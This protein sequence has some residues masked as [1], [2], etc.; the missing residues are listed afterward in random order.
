MGETVRL[1]VLTG[2]HKGNRYCFRKGGKTTVGRSADCDICVCGADRDLTIS[3]HHCGLKFDP[4]NV[5]VEDLRSSNG[6]Y[7]NGYSCPPPIAAKDGDILTIGG[8]SMQISIVDCAEWD[9]SKT[10]LV[11][12][13]V[14][15]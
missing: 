14:E 10:I 9:E 2:P 8:T 7:V 15:C 11:N 6:T 1:T 5:L 4:P 3:R 12:C 13:P